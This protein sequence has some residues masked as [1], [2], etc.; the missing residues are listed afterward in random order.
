MARYGKVLSAIT[1]Y[2]LLAITIPMEMD[3]NCFRH[4]I[5]NADLQVAKHLNV[6][7]IIGKRA[8]PLHIL[9]AHNSF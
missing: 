1:D 2:D 6:L 7:T 4:V 9:I 8:S 5:V 3:A